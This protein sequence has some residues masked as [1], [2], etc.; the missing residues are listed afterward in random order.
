MLKLHG[1]PHM[2]VSYYS[3]F[4]TLVLLNMY[5]PLYLICYLIDFLDMFDH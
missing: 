5:S 2:H 3:F 4:L 1:T